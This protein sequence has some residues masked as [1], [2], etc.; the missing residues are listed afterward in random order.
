MLFRITAGSGQQTIHLKWAVS[1]EFPEVTCLG[2]LKTSLTLGKGVLFV[3][4][5]LLWEI[6]IHITS[7]RWGQP[8]QMYLLGYLNSHSYQM[9]HCLNMAISVW[10]GGAPLERSSWDFGHHP[11]QSAFRYIPIPTCVQV[12]SISR[13][14]TQKGHIQMMWHNDG[15]S[16]GFFCLEWLWVT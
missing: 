15:N 16:L 7:Q 13:C 14:P 11:F 10:T 1:K 3:P 8:A 4:A 12:W 9:P 2:M 5:E 6:P